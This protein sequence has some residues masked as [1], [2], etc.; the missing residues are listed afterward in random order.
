MGLCIAVFHWRPDHFW[1]STPH[2]VYSAY[3]VWQEMNRVED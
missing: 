3:E 2:E 1:Q